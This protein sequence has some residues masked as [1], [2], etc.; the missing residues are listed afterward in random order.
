MKIRAIILLALL[1]TAAFFAV[2][3]QGGEHWRRAEDWYLDFL[4]ANARDHFE[5]EAMSPSPDVVFVEFNERDKAE[6]GS[7][8]PP[9][10]DYLSV[11]KR[12]APHE[13]ELVA[14][15]DVLS[16]P[17]DKPQSP[18][19][20]A[21]QALQQQLER[22][23]QVLLAFS[24]KVEGQGAGAPLAVDDFSLPDVNVVGD[25]ISAVP[26]LTGGILPDRELRLQVQLGF[27]APAAEGRSRFAARDDS[28]VVPS[29]ALQAVALKGHVLPAEVRLRLGEGAALY[30]GHARFVPLSKDGTL[31]PKLSGELTRVNAIDLLTPDLGDESARAAAAKLSDHKLI[32]LGIAGSAVENEARIAS[33][34]LALPGIQ[35]AAAAVEWSG[36]GVGALL[37]FF[38]LRFRRLGALFIGTG[39]MVVCIA[40]FVGVFQSSLWWM[41]P[42]GPLTFIAVGT[43]FAFIWPH[44]AKTTEAAAEP[45]A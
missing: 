21:K 26:A 38:L 29:F 1:G 2:K 42:L 23:P 39:I 24:G 6:F 20:L 9:P 32:M 27:V 10:D 16:W 33:W 41:F 3:E 14:I 35:S 22:F 45:T 28:R 19:M 44:R 37:A 40:I 15:G 7:W 8:P 11:L 17:E 13:P 4:T 43:L 34:A 36:T 25:D 31:T 18:V 5:R 30:A 12:I